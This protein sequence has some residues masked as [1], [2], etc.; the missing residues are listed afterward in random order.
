MKTLLKIVEK[1][2]ICILLIIVAL[3]QLYNSQFDSLTPWKGGGFGMF[4]TNKRANITAVGY[5]KNGDSILINVIG[6]KY[7]VPISRSFLTSTK[8]YP[9]RKK[10][11]KLG[12]LIV[13]SYLTPKKLE[14]PVNID[15]VSAQIIDNNKSFY[16]SIYV[17][18]Y[19][20]SQKIAETEKAIEVESVK[21]TLY[22]TNFFEKDLLFKKRYVDEILVKKL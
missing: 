18:K 10:L 1:Y 16:N 3:I 15:T 2:L 6:S 21:I 13:N 14:I 20:Q 19:Y 8:N 17:P 11:E 9:K 7:D 5:T 22:E 12:G 4:S